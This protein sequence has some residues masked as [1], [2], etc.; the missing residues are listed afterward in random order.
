MYILKTGECHFPLLWSS[1]KQSSIARS[2]TEAEVIALASGMFGEAFNLHTLAEQV[3]E[4]GIAMTFCQDNQAAISVIQAG[5]STKLRHCGRV[6]RVNVASVHEQLERGNANIE[7]CHTF[8]QLANGFTK[9]IGPQEWIATLTQMCLERYSAGRG[10][11]H[12]LKADSKNSFQ[13]MCTF[14]MRGELMKC[15]LLHPS[16]TPCSEWHSMP[17]C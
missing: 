4:R 10:M 2:T 8:Q 9:V 1:K 14:G 6:H 13:G 3:T 11:G 17:V 5:Y 12:P 15:M 7:Y 16:C